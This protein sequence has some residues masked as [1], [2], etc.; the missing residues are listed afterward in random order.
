MTKCK[1]K[2]T[3]FSRCIE[4][5][6][7]GV[8]GMHTFCSD[9]GHCMDGHQ[10]EKD[11]KENWIDN[12]KVK[13]WIEKNEIDKDLVE[14]AEVVRMLCV[15]TPYRIKEIVAQAM[16][17]VRDA[18]KS[19]KSM[20]WGQLQQSR[21]YVEEE[22][23]ISDMLVGALEKIRCQNDSPPYGDFIG[24]SGM[25]GIADEAIESHRKAREGK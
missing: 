22:R 13:K 20:L 4:Q 6:E 16:Q 18:T 24:D 8:E 2:N 23:K 1:H 7:H 9:C 11:K 25:V 10:D 21:K 12:K 3:W 15:D 17:E 5:C 19:D 14:K